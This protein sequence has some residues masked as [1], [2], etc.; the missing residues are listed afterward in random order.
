[1]RADSEGHNEGVRAP[2]DTTAKA[3]SSSNHSSMRGHEGSVRGGSRR[4]SGEFA[5]ALSRGAVATTGP[6]AA[7]EKSEPAVRQ[8][9]VP[10]TVPPQASQHHSAVVPAVSAFAHFPQRGDGSGSGEPPYFHH[11][12]TCTE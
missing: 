9:S 12:N 4:G 3:N 1:M 6:T 7:S 10:Q 8:S 2:A 5:P 11:P